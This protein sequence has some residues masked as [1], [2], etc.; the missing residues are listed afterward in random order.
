[1]S[2]WSKE[3]ETMVKAREIMDKKRDIM[4]KPVKE[5]IRYWRE[6][7]DSY[8][9]I[10]KKVNRFDAKSKATGKA[11]Y[12]DD[13]ILP[14]MLHG[15]ILRSPYAHARIVNIDT[16][17][18]EKLPG[19]KA[20]ITGKDVPK[21][22]MFG[23]D[24]KDEPFLA[25]DGIVRY[26]GQEVAAV[27][28]TDKRTA[29]EAIRLIKVDYEELPAVLN[30]DEAI[31]PCAPQV[32]DEV[33]VLQEDET[34]AKEKIQDNVCYDIYYERGNPEQAFK[35]ADV[36]VEDEFLYSDVK[37]AY[38]EPDGCVAD[39]DLGSGKLT[40]W[41]G[42]Q[43]PSN[44]KDMVG[45]N[46]GL[47][48]SKIRVIQNA[49]GG[50]FGSR[51]TALQLHHIAALLS[52]KALRPVKVIRTKTED[53]TLMRSRGNMKIRMRLGAKK[54]GTIIAE[55]TKILV[56]N[57]AYQYINRRRSMHM[58]ERND[59]LYRVYNVRHEVK[60]IYTN[61]TPCGTYR[62]FGDAQMSWARESLVDMLAEK[63]N[64]DAVE[65]RLKN[66][67][68]TG[69]ITAN[70][71]QIKSCGL[72]EC[73]KKVSEVIGWKEKVQQKNENG[74]YRRA[75]GIACTCHETDDRST[76][77]FC[78]SV[79]YIKILE[80]GGARLYSGEAEFG[81]G[82]HNAF[83]MVVVEELG[84]PLERI[85]VVPHD[86]D[87]T[88]W[89]FSSTGSRV[90]TAGLN[91]TYLACQD[92]K[93]KILA[94]AAEMLEVD[95]EDLV[96]KKGKIYFVGSEKEA[97][98]LADVAKYAMRKM[99]GSM[100]VAEGVEERWHTE[101][102]L[103][104]THPTHYGPGV[105]ANYYDTTAVELEVNTENGEIKLLNVVVAD[106]CGKV[107]DR[108]ML[109]GQVDGATM[110]GIGAALTEEI[111]VDSK[112]RIV[113]ANLTDYKVPSASNVPPIQKIFVESIDPS[114]AYGCKGGGESP[115]IGS[116]VPAIANAVYRATGVRIKSTPI[117]REKV[118]KAITEKKEG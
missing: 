46:F 34:F 54:D 38:M 66:A 8:D 65:F 101:Y 12:V 100:I 62:S 114:F 55:H 40:L 85:D 117:S 47:D 25:W 109:E 45:M 76:D 90:M 82:A 105:D 110:Q 56:D 53:L 22:F 27:A 1:M 28:A 108:K 58:L 91:A 23:I 18:A 2:K 11:I 31:K 96:F 106:D 24:V 52:M 104:S 103:K 70:G 60:N 115:G 98:L 107:I 93:K 80:D 9:V 13:V 63:L 94:N 21:V 39:Y 51:F 26:V 4:T 77:G 68:Q 59:A 88:H 73:L 111:I 19:V 84:I 17:E 75:V 99:G 48:H 10:G 71:F 35:E 69:C 20:I 67:M 61:K 79:S 78:G 41:V 97:L 33:W 42:T 36:I 87:R 14:N 43:W 3:I 72:T 57:G 32:H 89:G 113:N 30:V 5:R 50:A 92:A 86:T 112:G 44:V 6:R 95:P 116:V 118:L 15:K 37:A 81:Q 7:K 16:S 29:E 83:A 64:M 49:V 74:K 102:V